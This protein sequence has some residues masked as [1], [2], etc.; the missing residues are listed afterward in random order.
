MAKKL[1]KGD[2]Q[3]VE[4]EEVVDGNETATTSKYSAA[5]YWHDNIRNQEA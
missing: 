2:Q 4:A 1:K 5:E 3:E